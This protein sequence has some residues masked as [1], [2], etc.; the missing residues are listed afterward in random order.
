MICQ[1]CRRETAPVGI[2]DSDRKKN[3]NLCDDCTPP[4]CAMVAWIN[5]RADD[6]EPVWRCPS[7]GELVKHGLPILRSP[8]GVLHY[9][10]RDCTPP[11]GWE[12]VPTTTIT[13]VKAA[14]PE[15]AAALGMKYE[16]PPLHVKEAIERAKRKRLADDW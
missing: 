13:A 9:R 16:E 11:S 7:C 5:K 8:L 2:Y 4:R 3:Y 14:T 12:I 15:V 10:H 1:D 6:P